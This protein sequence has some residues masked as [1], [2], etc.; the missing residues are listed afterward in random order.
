MKASRLEFFL[1][2]PPSIRLDGRPLAFARRKTAAMLYYL[3]CRTEALGRSAAAGLLWPEF[4]PEKARQS[5]RQAIYDTAS[6]AGRDLVE[7]SKGFLRLKPD[8][9]VSN[10]SSRFVVLARKGLALAETAL[11]GKYGTA[12]LRK[13]CDTL[14]EAEFAYRGEF[15]EGFFLDDSV[16][17]EE[18]QL[19]EAEGLRSLASSVETALGRLALRAGDR[20][21]AESRARRAIEMEPWSELSHCLLVEALAAGGDAGAALVHAR[22]YGEALKKEFGRAPGLPFLTLVERMERKTGNVP[23]PGDGPEPVLSVPREP[24][25]FIPPGARL[26]YTP[27]PMIG[28]EEALEEIEAGLTGGRLLTL[29]G[30]GGMGKTRLAVAAASWMEGRFREGVRFVDLVPCVRD[31]DVPSAVAQALGIRAGGDALVPFLRGRPL[32][33]VLD[34]CEHVLEGAAS[35]ASLV[36]SSCPEVPVLATSREPLA[37]DGELVFDLPPLALP[38][39]GDIERNPSVILRAPATRLFLERARANAPG[40][41]ASDE[42]AVD[43]AAICR[44]LDGLPLAIELAAS[45]VPGLGPRSLRNL[46]EARITA[47]LD[48]LDGC[49]R[50]SR[51]AHRSLSAVFEWSWEMLDDD[52]RRCLVRLSVFCGSFSLEAACGVARPERDTSLL[53]LADKR[54]VVPLRGSDGAARFRLLETVRAWATSRLEDMGDEADARRAHVSWYAA[55]SEA[56]EK[57]MIA[58]ADPAGFWA[59]REDLDEFEAA[60]RYASSLPGLGAAAVSMLRALRDLFA[61]SGA[62]NRFG[63]LFDLIDPALAGSGDGRTRADFLMA[64]GTRKYWN[65][66]SGFAADFRA[67]AEAYGALG[68]RDLEAW[69]LACADYVD[70]ENGYT[71]APAECAARAFAIFS[72]LGSAEG[73]VTAL[74]VQGWKSLLGHNDPVAAQEIL[75]RALGLARPLGKDILMGRCLMLAAKTAMAFR[76]DDEALEHYEACRRIFEKMDDADSLSEVCYNEAILR[77]RRDDVEGGLEAARGCI[78]YQRRLGNRI[79]IANGQRLAAMGLDLLGQDEEAMAMIEEAAATMPQ[80]APHGERIMMSCAIAHLESCR[81]N[82]GRAREIIEELVAGESG[83]TEEPDRILDAWFNLGRFELSWGHPQAAAEAFW[84]VLREAELFSQADRSFVMEALIRLGILEPESCDAARLAELQAAAAE[85]NA[86]GCQLGAMALG[87]HLA[88]ARHEDRGLEL[89]SIAIAYYL[90]RPPFFFLRPE[91]ALAE[92]AASILRETFGKDRVDALLAEA[93][94][95]YGRDEVLFMRYYADVLPFVRRMLESPR[96]EAKSHILPA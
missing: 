78:E 89:A 15:L 68:E 14:T 23:V 16:T 17:F 3:A 29:V 45:R 8:L 87:L 81:G 75:E 80:T 77:Y 22:A 71:T 37:I 62:M 32:L 93:G 74:L 40:F 88:V 6:T 43:I 24:P 76:R 27:L 46:L 18:W 63:S 39:P 7:G 94:S 19:E 59:F 90:G 12:D 5:L 25:P 57:G 60:I 21:E 1:L 28:R 13:A 36:T 82:L 11:G 83:H 51:V 33:L 70:P 42:D 69:A 84:R 30:A 65:F 92:R 53:R 72:D 26:P 79:M 48:L 56:V 50:S 95:R 44:Q 58:L 52:E 86:P 66:D 34:N 4:P 73:K 2:G 85:A 47:P 20:Q 41:A 10:D 61:A 31:G 9:D 67:A 54:L 38:A 96:P 35:V 91:R 64:R 49:S 55:R